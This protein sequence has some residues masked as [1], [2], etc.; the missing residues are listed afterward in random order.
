MHGSPDY[1]GIVPRIV[2]DLLSRTKGEDKSGVYEIKFSYFE[3][4]NE[5]IYDL[6]V[7]KHY[8]KSVKPNFSVIYSFF[9]FLVKYT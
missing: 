2:S 6:L 9:F 1:P 8:Q 5:K 7:D 3:I 4:Y